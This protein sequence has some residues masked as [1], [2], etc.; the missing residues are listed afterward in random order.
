MTQA[1]TKVSLGFEPVP[2]SRAVSKMLGIQVQLFPQGP[3]APLSTRNSLAPDK[4][5]LSLLLPQGAR[6]ILFLFALTFS[7]MSLAGSQFSSPT[8][9]LK[10]EKHLA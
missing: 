3:L 9:Y 5:Y 1:S 6:L 8:F 4:A 10:R 2:I 7:I